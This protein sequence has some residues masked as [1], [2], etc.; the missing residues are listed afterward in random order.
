MII[1][2]RNEAF[3]HN[4]CKKLAQL[5]KVIF[6]MSAQAKDR[7]DECLRVQNAYENLIADLVE[8]HH[9]KAEAIAKSLVQFRKGCVEGA[10]REWGALYKR[11]KVNFAN[12]S[13][14]QNAKIAEIIDEAQELANLIK[15]IQIEALKH[16]TSVM[17]CADELQRDLKAKTRPTTT[18]RRKIRETL[19]PIF[20]KI[21]E[22]NEAADQR[23]KELKAAHAKEIATNR[24]EITKFLQEELSKR[25]STFV[26]YREKLTGLEGDVQSLRD[27]HSGIVE[28]WNAMMAEHKEARSGLV[29]E[30]KSALRKIR[31]DIKS[32]KAKDKLNQKS[33]AAEMN[34]LNQ[35]FS[36][37][38]KNHKAE[39]DAIRA[40]T[41]S[42]RRQRK[43]YADAH[44]NS[45]KKRSQEDQAAEEKMK[46][47][48]RIE[49]KRKE[50]VQALIMQNISE[51]EA[52]TAKLIE[53]MQEMINSSI[54]RMNS[55]ILVVNG[56]IEQQEA[57]AQA[58]LDQEKAEFMKR[59][60]ERLEVLQSAIETQIAS[61]DRAKKNQKDLVSHL[62]RDYDEL[63][64]RQAAELDGKNKKL[65]EEIE[66]VKR[67]NK[68]RLGEKE[69]EVQKVLDKRSDDNQKKLN[70]LDANFGKDL[71]SKT[72]LVTKEI[73]ELKQK[74]IQELEE[75]VRSG[76]TE[77]E[78]EMQV[79]K[80]KARVTAIDGTIKNALNERE[81]KIAHLD[82]EIA[83][84]EKLKRQLERKKKTESQ[85]ID[86]EYERKIQVEQV[87]LREKV[88]NIAKL[89]DAEENKR[90][91]EI[92][93]AIRKVKETNN[94]TDD[95]LNRKRHELQS[96]VAEYDKTIDD[97]RKEINMYN[98]D[99]KEEELAKA[100]EKT[101]ADM[102]QSVDA[103]KE[104]Q[105][106]EQNDSK[107]L[108][109]SQEKANAD[110]FR[111]LEQQSKSSNDEYQKEIARIKEQ[112][113]KVLAE[114]E[115]AKQEC[116]REFDA[117]KEKLHKDHAVAIDRMKARITAAHKLRDEMS[118]KYEAERAKAVQKNQEEIEQR[119]QEN[120]SSNANMFSQAGKTSEDLSIKISEL[121][122]Q[123]TDV[124]LQIIDPQVR[125]TE[126][127][128]MN[129]LKLQIE[130]L[131][132]T[133]ES[134][135]Q[136][137]YTT[138]R[139]A[140]TRVRELE[141]QV[142]ISPAPPPSRERKVNTQSSSRS[143]RRDVSRVITPVDRAR[144]R[145][146]V[147]ITPQ[148]SY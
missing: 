51:C 37:T 129:V 80:A 22:V 62:K 111:N 36:I 63:K 100:I 67:A 16:A 146:Q 102:V 32:L 92:I 83:H 42:Q 99:Q 78:H 40:Q 19:K 116:Q 53:S 132:E 128:K 66:K 105:K 79:N 26:E 21:D 131:A 112:R 54:E 88:D 24:S 113:Q 109:K 52:D 133:Q 15:S 77:S 69:V 85:S 7:H 71:E 137:F 75:Q 123:Q 25:R 97:L 30:T 104:R 44:E 50:E 91:I 46:K 127:R 93:E 120:V 95:F 8:S 13:S 76:N 84:L 34:D 10:C 6:S 140:P 1:T 145:P 90:G 31:L 142:K 119:S 27:E 138:I 41:H 18:S 38:K 11:L 35:Q 115:K 5:A 87:H 141:P 136:T 39:I 106:K 68:S 122:K 98:G 29:S 12:L 101:K 86:E 96:L 126:K 43:N 3:K 135:F 72:T 103:I 121:S 130:S 28:Q 14:T 47:K 59:G 108:M 48:C 148:L 94:H 20:E 124:E 65:L 70:Q 139:S 125:E 17:D 58:R 4:S 107:E 74:R 143:S 89:F 81:K 73:S 45:M 57:E 110:A 134:T 23:I 61:D 144:R 82:S 55:R 2:D 147:L 64:K 56:K 114:T 49:K 60:S 33:H 118:Q 117:K 9:T